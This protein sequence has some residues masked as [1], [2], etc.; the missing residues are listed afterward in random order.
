MPEKHNW[1][2]IY[3]T[4]RY[5]S[6]W[7]CKYLC[8]HKHGLPRWHGGKDLLAGIGDSRDLGLIPELKRFP[9]VGNGNPLEYSCLENPLEESGRLESMGLLRVG[10]DLAYTHTYI[11]I[12]IYFS[13]KC[14]YMQSYNFYRNYITVYITLENIYNSVE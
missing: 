5:I 13:H 10:C 4:H 2:K 8:I 14:I 3:Y 11:N 1:N 6:L 7:C 12:C 9:G